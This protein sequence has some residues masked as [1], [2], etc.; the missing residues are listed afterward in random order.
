MFN[1]QYEMQGIKF[2]CSFLKTDNKLKA[3]HFLLNIEN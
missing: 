3:M 2:H 1:S